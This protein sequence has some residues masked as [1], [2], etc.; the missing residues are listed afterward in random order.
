MS[1]IG[2]W[3]RRVRLPDRG[4]TLWHL[5]ESEIADRFVMRCGREMRAKRDLPFEFAAVSAI[6]RR[7]Y[8]CVGGNI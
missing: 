7:C 3:A 6:G 1:N 2:L 4:V 8:Q 5:I